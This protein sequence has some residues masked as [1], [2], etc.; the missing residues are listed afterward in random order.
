MKICKSCNILKNIIFFNKDR[1]E[2]DGLNSRCRECINRRRNSIKNEVLIESKICKSCNIEKSVD[3]FKKQKENS[4]G[5]YHMCKL[6]FNEWRKEYRKNDYVKK[7]ESEFRIKNKEYYTDYAKKWKELNADK[8]SM[9]HKN[10]NNK[11]YRKEYQKRFSKLNQKK[12]RQTDTIFRLSGNVRSYIRQ[13]IKN[14]KTSSTI[15]IIGCSF[16]DYK[17]YLESKFESWMTWENYGKYNG[18]KN[19][20]WDIDHIIP[21]SSAKTEEELLMLKRQKIYQME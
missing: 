10:S 3:C 11:P 6:C 8:I 12:R 2:K 13:I 15:D 20:G 16:D 19:Y 4:D 7:S 17:K 1:R 18:E 9:Y 21:L 5:L 14:K